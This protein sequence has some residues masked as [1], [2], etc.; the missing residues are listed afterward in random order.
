MNESILMVDDDANLLAGMKRAFRKQ[1]VIVTAGSGEE[2][3]QHLQST[4]FAAVVSD[5]RMPAMDGVAFLTAARSVQ[6]HATRILLTGYADL[7]TATGAINDGHI[8]RL[9]TKPVSAAD[10]QK[11]LQAAVEQ[12]RL[13]TAERELLSKTLLGSIKVLLDLLGRSCPAA[14]KRSTRMQIIIRRMS[15]ELGLSDLWQYEIA[16]MLSQVSYLLAPS[17]LLH[18]FYSGRQLSSSEQQQMTDLLASGRT[19]LVQI[20]RL[21]TVAEIIGRQQWVF[22]PHAFSIDIDQRDTITLGAQMLQT[23]NE[24]EA[25]LARGQTH[26]QAIRNLHFTVTLDGKLV[27]VLDTV[28]KE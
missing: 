28:V 3:L 6:P 17:A 2:G 20:P 10:M 14:M 5:F 9:L 19:L 7:N 16:A 26:E 23:A 18:K 15:T 25:Q 4:P 13:V 22:S 12:N 27:Q 21:E 11:A 1:F 8:F 24:Y